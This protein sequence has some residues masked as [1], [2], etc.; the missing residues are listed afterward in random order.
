MVSMVGIV[1]A[2]VS[3]ILHLTFA[4]QNAIMLSTHL[5]RHDWA[6]GT[7]IG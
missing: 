1:V 4:I 5:E 7:F 3:A 6:S 2:A